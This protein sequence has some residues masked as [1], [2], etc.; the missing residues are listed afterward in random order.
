MAAEGDIDLGGW[1]QNVGGCTA[2]RKGH[3]SRIDTTFGGVSP[4]KMG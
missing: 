3:A 1:G 2:N 4:G